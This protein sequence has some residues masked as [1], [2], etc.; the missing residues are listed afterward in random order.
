MVVYPGWYRGCIASPGGIPRVVQV[1]ICPPLPYP[2]VYILGYT[3]P[4]HTTLGTPYH[5]LYYPVMTYTTLSVREACS[6][7]QKRRNPWVRE[8]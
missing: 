1:C 5:V 6:W 7:T 8:A 2:G 4:Y 3:P